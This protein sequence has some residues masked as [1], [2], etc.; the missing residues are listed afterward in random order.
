MCSILIDNVSRL[1]ENQSNFSKSLQSYN[2]TPTNSAP[3]TN[4]ASSASRPYMEENKTVK[5][6]IPQDIGCAGSEQEY[7]K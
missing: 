4:F 1:K 2:L 3:K 7:Q 6:Q 5:L